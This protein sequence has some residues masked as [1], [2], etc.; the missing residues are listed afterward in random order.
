MQSVK[1]VTAADEVGVMGRL[2]GE[3]AG[4]VE[5]GAA[6]SERRKRGEKKID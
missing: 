3:H 2:E 1:N 4:E 6:F 5:S